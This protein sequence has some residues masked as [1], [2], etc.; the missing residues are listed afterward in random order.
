MIALPCVECG[1]EVEIDDSECALYVDEVCA[2]NDGECTAL[3]IDDVLC[4]ECERIDREAATAD[5]NG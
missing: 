5:W 1:A 4:D 3:G 2:C